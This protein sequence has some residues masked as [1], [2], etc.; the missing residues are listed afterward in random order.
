MIFACCAAPA[1]NATSQL[2]LSGS[3]DSGYVMRIV[4]EDRSMGCGRL[5]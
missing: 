4:G 2:N 5:E 1:P 3:A